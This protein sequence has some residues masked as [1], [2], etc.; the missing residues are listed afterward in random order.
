[1]TRVQMITRPKLFFRKTRTC[2]NQHYNTRRHYAECFK[3]SVDRL[4]NV[5]PDDTQ[6]KSK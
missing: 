2:D 1:M 5:V 4:N 3:L 6:N